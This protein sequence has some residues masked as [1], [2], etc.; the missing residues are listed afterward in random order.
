MT[1]ASPF[2]VR[3]TD[4][5][6][7]VTPEQAAKAFLVSIIGHPTAPADVTPFRFCV[8]GAVPAWST[9]SFNYITPYSPG[10]WSFPRTVPMGTQYFVTELQFASKKVRHPADPGNMRSSYAVFNN[11]MTMTEHMPFCSY[12]S[13][14]I[15]PAGFVITGQWMNNSNE[16]QNMIAAM[17]GYVVPLNPSNQ[18]E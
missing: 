12:R 9:L 6:V 2:L 18:S 11:V 10:A 7:S 17:H 5:P 4:S 14:L 16:P 8:S 15:L 13:P 1:T 3:L